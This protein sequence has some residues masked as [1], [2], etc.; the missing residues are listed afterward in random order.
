MNNN[1]GKLEE[2]PDEMIDRLIE[3]M[4]TKGQSSANEVKA[5]E[6][7]VARVFEEN[8]FNLAPRNV[9]PADDGMYYWYQPAGSQKSG[10]FLVFCVEGGKKT[11]EVLF[12]A[13]HTNDT[14]FKLN[15]GWFNK[16]TVYIIS[17][18][19]ATGRGLPR[20][21]ICFIGLGQ[22][23]PTDKDIPAND[24]CNRLK[25]EWNTMRKNIE[26]DFLSIYFRL[27]NGYSTK[28]FTPDF[29]AHRFYKTVEWLQSYV[30]PSL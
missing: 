16:D 8:R 17:F 7:C 4:E 14:T 11:D 23:I 20:K 13:K 26:T 29:T 30:E 6:A 1:P 15:D 19:V 2:H 5:H 27:A 24:E 9:V 12:D 10:D 21:L 25:K 22:D 3:Y 18:R 28:Q